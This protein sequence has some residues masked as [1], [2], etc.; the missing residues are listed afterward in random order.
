MWF[1]GCGDGVRGC[2]AEGCRGCRGGVAVRGGG[3]LG[4]CEFFL[5]VGGWEVARGGRGGVT[6]GG[7][8]IIFREK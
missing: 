4:E 8:R 3:V 6:S 5:C 2:G 7:S 1:V